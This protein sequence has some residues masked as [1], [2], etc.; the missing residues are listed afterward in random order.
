MSVVRLA[1]ASDVH[2]REHTWASRPNLFGDSYYSLDQIRR[3]CIKN[4]LPLLLPGDIFQANKP[5]SEDVEWFRDVM[6]DM[7]LYGLPVYFIQGQHD[8]ATPPWPTAIHSWPVSIHNNRIQLAPDIAVLGFDNMGQTELEIALD[9]MD[10]VEILVLHQMA[11][12]VFPHEGSWN[13]KLDWVKDKAKVVALG[14]YHEPVTFGENPTAFYTGSMHLQSTSEPTNK[15]FVVLEYD[16]QTGITLKRIPLVTRRVITAN[17]DSAE[18]LSEFAAGITEILAK[19]HSSQPDDIKL[20]KRAAYFENIVTVPILLVN[21]SKDVV[22]VESTVR[23]VCGDRFHI[24]LLP[25]SENAPAIMTKEIDPTN[26]LVSCIERY[27]KKDTDEYNLCLELLSKS[28]GQEII[29]SWRESYEVGVAD[30]LKN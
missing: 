26:V 18:R 29:N 22:G 14:D 9:G 10:P 16:T 23:S 12:E 30:N 21:Y 17:I 2:I 24:W 5:T 28:A 1:I 3:Y 11:H 27:A 8:R 20:S 4:N 15:S 25:I 13:L 7:Q 19:L 6:D